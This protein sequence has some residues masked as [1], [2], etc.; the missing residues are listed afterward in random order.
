MERLEIWRGRT[1]SKREGEGTGRKASETGKGARKEKKTRDLHRRR[2][3]PVQTPPG[4]CI[5]DERRGRVVR[6]GE[7]HQVARERLILDELDID[8]LSDSERSVRP[9]VRETR[10][11]L[12]RREGGAVDGDDDG[13]RG[14]RC[15]ARERR[16]WVE[17]RVGVGGVP[18][19]VGCP[20]KG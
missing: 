3:S 12:V 1:W 19:F 8:C 6:D 17:R 4:G 11:V 9:R 2:R 5:A 14:R 15:G 7:R 13:G 16:R 20:V 10:E 18:V